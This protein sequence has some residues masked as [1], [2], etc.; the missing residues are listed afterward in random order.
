[1]CLVEEVYRME[2]QERRCAWRDDLWYLL[3]MGHRHGKQGKK[4]H[5]L[6]VKGEAAILLLSYRI[7]CRDGAV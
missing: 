7:E 3:T 2:A 5:S 1:M 6:L 4:D